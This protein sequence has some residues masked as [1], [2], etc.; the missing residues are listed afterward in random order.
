[1]GEYARSAAIARAVSEHWPS[2]AIQF[3]LSR[4]APYAGGVPF[5]TA[6]L[7]SSATFHTAAIIELMQAWRPQVVIFD[8]AGRTAQLLAA[9][10]L[11]ARVIYISS[12][13]R[14]RGKAFRL[15][16][17]RLIDEHWIAYPE[18]LAGKLSFLERLKLARLRRPVVRFLDVIFSR[19][20]PARFEALLSQVGCT[21]GNFALIVP[22]GGTGHPETRRASGQFLAAARALAARGIATV[23]VGP[24]KETP[25]NSEPAA[26][27]ANLRLLSAL[28]QSDLAAFMCGA[29][30]VVANGG[31]TLLQAIA[32][33]AACVAVPIAGD[34]VERIRRCVDAGVAVETR[35]D[36]A[37]IGEAA[38]ALWDNEPER[39]ALAKRASAL[40]LAD[41]LE[42][43]VGAL[44]RLIEAREF[45]G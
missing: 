44:A 15:R 1:M 33:G 34:Q 9:Q 39:A 6:W 37:H 5:P 30:L 26:T 27:G 8:N 18:F 17:M 3:A 2:A 42:V 22:G 12:R 16:W 20:T 43:A 38:T 13:R 41:G 31:S 4:A 7:D 10:R 29:R 35:L 11:G 25:S 23:F 45:H 19:S 36:A 14:Q 32:C 24:T 21:A 40:A 28:P